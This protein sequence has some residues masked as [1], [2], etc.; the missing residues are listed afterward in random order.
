MS[1]SFPEYDDLPAVK[2]MPK[3]CAWGVFDKNGER[4]VYGC[5]NKITPEAVKA[6]AAEVK[7]GHSI[8]LK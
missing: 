6:A 7:V 5:L 3:G 4:D 1:S 8:S 2:G